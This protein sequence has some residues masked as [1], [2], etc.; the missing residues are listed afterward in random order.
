MVAQFQQAVNIYNPIGYPGDLAFDGPIRAA[1]FN[2]VS[3]P[4]P[5]VIGYAFTQSSPANPDPVYNVPNSSTLASPVAG[6]ARAGGTGVFAGILQN[7]KEQALY[8]TSALN[9]LG[10]S[11][12]LPENSIGSLLTMGYL[13]VNLPGPA[14]PGDLVT[15]D[16]N[17]GALNSIAPVA[18][19]T[20]SIAAGG[21]S[22]PDVMTV[23]AV[24][25][26]QLVIGQQIVG[27]GVPAGTYI[28]SLGTGKGYTGTY[29]LSSINT[30]TVA[31]EAMTAT[32]VPPAS[33]SVTGHIDP[34]VA[35]TT[36]PSVLTVSAVGSG[37]LRI[38]DLLTGTGIPAN[39]VI[40]SFGSGVGGTGTYNVNQIN[41]TIASE[42][43][44][45]PTNAL[46]PNAVV[47]RF[48]ANTLGGVAVIKLT[49]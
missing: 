35:P 8:G 36:D 39:T 47:E 30:L 20:A 41:L 46:V 40:V 29:N 18:Q 45:G 23:T 25:A 12:S 43:I 27:A 6:T 1:P 2:L 13:F 22:T 42:T 10:A 38:G 33:F 3:T 4:N 26:G 11:I 15:Y 19:F 24:A 48:A 32:N 21:A 34:G 9:P 28:L 17:T 7:S 5:N 16:T 14:N 49:N 31:S 37:Q 44:T